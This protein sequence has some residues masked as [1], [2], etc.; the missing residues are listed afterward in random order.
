MT[1]INLQP[2][3]QAVPEEPMLLPY[4]LQENMSEVLYSD[5]MGKLLV[6][7]SNLHEMPGLWRT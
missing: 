7:D 4:I 5:L 2:E 3:Q 6:F 1:G